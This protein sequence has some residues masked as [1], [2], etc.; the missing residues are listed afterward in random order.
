MGTMRTMPIHGYGGLIPMG[1]KALGM[2]HER[3]GVSVR[4]EKAAGMKTDLFARGPESWESWV[5]RTEF[6]EMARCA[7]NGCRG[8]AD[9]LSMVRKRIFEWRPQG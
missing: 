8:C 5:R 4:K 7:E 9:E 1:T 2:G 6:L 3:N